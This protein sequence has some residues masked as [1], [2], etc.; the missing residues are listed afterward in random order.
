[1]SDYDFPVLANVDFG[2]HHISSIPMSIGLS[3]EL[4]TKNHYFAIREAAV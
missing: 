4:D 2:H 3:A 1:M